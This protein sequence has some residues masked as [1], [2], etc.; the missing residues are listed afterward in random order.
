MTYLWADGEPIRMES[1]SQGRPQ[2]FYWQGRTHRLTHIR[3]RWQ[4]QTDWWSDEGAVWR[5]YL[6]V[7]TA[8]GLLCVLYQDLVS[9]GWYLEKVY[10]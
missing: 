8:E 7:A 4:V 2:R 5:D 9:E 3:K 6:A 1:D 10:D